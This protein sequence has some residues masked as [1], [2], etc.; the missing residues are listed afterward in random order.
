MDIEYIKT[1]LHEGR[2]IKLS[3]HSLSDTTQAFLQSAILEILTYYSKE[4]L[5]LATYTVLFEATM[6]AVKA[7]AKKAFFHHAEINPA[8]PGEYSSGTQ[9]FKNLINEN[10]IQTYSELAK[11]QGLYTKIIIAHSWDGLNIQVWNNSPLLPQ[12]EERIRKR[13][14][15][16]QR[17]NS[18]VDFYADNADNTEG[19]GLGLV[20]SI[21]MLK[22]E[23]IPIS[24]FRVGCKEGITKARVEI[25]F[26][27]NYLSERQKYVLEQEQMG[28]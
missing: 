28:F 3:L 17:Y 24:D 7:N 2:T 1:S 8:I 25:P 22:Q 18:I 10:Q 13:L 9:A 16:G 11:H 15:L 19:E 26:T 14:Q 23:G 12:E 5:F 4:H 6:N 20:V 27:S 21:L